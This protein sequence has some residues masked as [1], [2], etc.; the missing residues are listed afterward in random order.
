MSI[1]PSSQHD[2]QL[3]QHSTDEDDIVSYK[4]SRDTTNN[5]LTEGEVSPGR[6][7]WRVEGYEKRLEREVRSEAGASTEHDHLGYEE[8]DL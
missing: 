1:Y 6:V 2:C 3:E 7:Q 8:T 4:L 5:A